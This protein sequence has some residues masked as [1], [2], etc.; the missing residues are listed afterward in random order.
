MQEIV[1]EYFMFVSQ[2]FKVIRRDNDQPYD[3]KDIK[4]HHYSKASK[5]GQ[6]S[7]LGRIGPDLTRI[8]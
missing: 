6:K 7:G 4:F 5:V 8:M 1:V 3:L 2:N